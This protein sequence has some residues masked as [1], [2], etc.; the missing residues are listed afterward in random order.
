MP[1]ANASEQGKH[2]FILSG[3]SNMVRLNPDISFTPAVTKEFGEGNVIVVKDASGG[4]S[5]RRWYKRWESTKGKISNS[6]GDLYIR[7]MNKVNSATKG[8]EIIT[9]TFVWMQ[10]E[11]DAADGYGE[12]YED[13][14][15]GLMEQLKVDLNRN[16]IN[17]V[18]GRISDFDMNNNIHRHWTKVR[19][20]QVDLAES[21]L[22]GK[23][24]DTDD[25]NDGIDKSGNIIKNGLH[26]SV[27]GYWMLGNRFAEKAIELIKSDNGIGK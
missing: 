14:F 25:L 18:I 13:S 1:F 11:W 20:I 10:G 9:I 15:K 21:N 8:N 12:I 5:I 7:L 16:D 23:W 17:F 6:N 4:Q 26:Y 24:L 27:K 19:K 22:R 2:L 3:Q